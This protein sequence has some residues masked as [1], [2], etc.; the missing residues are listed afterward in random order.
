MEKLKKMF[1]IKNYIFLKKSLPKISVLFFSIILISSFAP[2]NSANAQVTDCLTS[3]V[4]RVDANYNGPIFLNAYWTDR[5]AS[6]VDETNPIELVVGPGEG[7]ATLAVE[8]SNRGPSELYSINGYLRLPTGFTPGGTSADPES[9]A[10]L[11]EIISKNIIDV[12]QAAYYGKVAEG[13]VFT[14]YY[15]VLITEDSTVGSYVSSSILDYSTADHM[16]SCK[17]SLLD[18]PFILPGKVILDLTTENIPLTPKIANEVEFFIS[19]KG[20]AD[21]TGGVLRILNIGDSAGSGGAGSSGQT[22]ITET[23]D[24]ELV[25]LG[26]NTFNIGTIP[27]NSTIT[28]STEIFPEATAGS[29]VQNIS[30]EIQYSNSYGYKQTD[31]LTTGLVVAPK[32]S[33]SPIIVSV[34]TAHDQP[35]VTAGMVENI[36]FEIA[37]SGNDNI[38]DLLVTLSGETTDMKIMGKSKWVISSLP[39]GETAE[40]ST[41]IFAATGLINNPSSF[42]LDLTYIS[43]GESN[44][45]TSNVG[46][47][48]AG[49][50]D[51]ELYDL[52][53]SNIGGSLYVV[54][55]ILNQG[56]T[57]G[58]FA[59]IELISFPNPSSEQTR[60]SDTIDSQQSQGDGSPGNGFSE[61]ASQGFN[62]NRAQSSGPQY[63]GDLTD[64]SSIPFSIPL[65]FSSLS[66]G[67]YP[68][69]FKLTYADDLRTFHE[70]LFDENINVLQIQQQTQP[71][72]RQ[73]QSDSGF[74]STEIILGII[75]AILVISIIVIYIRKTRGNSL[76]SDDLD[77]LLEDKSGPRIES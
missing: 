26:A 49:K 25:N 8:Y 57:T 40:I 17:S 51:L 10:Y 45:E 74:L 29:T 71:G 27:A 16:R 42:N 66:P 69:S 11:A 41:D 61:N 39:I 14:L 62:Q 22:L 21:A 47:F 13:G 76:P 55:N 48:I 43:D 1:I 60:N 31:L 44:L 20:S 67:T 34:D 12:S 56:S 72:G 54:G 52:Q 50:I 73:G 59:N 35:V 4:N 32:P 28:I 7:Q 75:V 18:V 24:T 64:D 3:T 37:N 65:P 58:K 2:Q 33:E 9:K 6:S 38:S 68:F 30:L 70:I 15:D 19:N 63:L 46:V 36:K 77:F 23:S 5:S 53:V